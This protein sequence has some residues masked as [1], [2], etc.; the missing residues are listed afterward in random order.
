MTK[1]N[2]N[3]QNISYFSICYQLD[4]LKYKNSLLLKQFVFFHGKSC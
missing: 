2:K 3:F 4:F 1:S